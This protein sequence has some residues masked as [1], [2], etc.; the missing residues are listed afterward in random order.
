MIRKM[1]PLGSGDLHGNWEQTVTGIC[2]FKMTGGSYAKN[3]WGRGGPWW[4][5]RGKLKVK[6]K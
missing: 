1:I 5:A 6:G 2:L 3:R 4:S